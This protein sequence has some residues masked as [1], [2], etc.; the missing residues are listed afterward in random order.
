MKLELT[1]SASTGCEF[2]ALSS[3]VIFDSI[4]EYVFGNMWIEPVKQV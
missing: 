4:W 2:L 3:G 1:G